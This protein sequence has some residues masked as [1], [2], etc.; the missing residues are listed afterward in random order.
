MSS[1]RTKALLALHERGTISRSDLVT[2]LGIT[3]STAAAIA[4]DLCQSGY[5]EESGGLSGHVGRP[6]RTLRALPTSL[7]IMS[8]ELR[9]DSCHV[10]AYGLGGTH[11]AR[12]SV[13]REM[14]DISPETAASV[15]AGCVASVAGALPQGSRWVATSIAVPGIVEE[16]SGFVA[17]APHLGW[18]DLSWGAHV[19]TAL[20]AKCPITFGNDA[21]LGALGEH[22]R[23]AGR[24]VEAML[25]VAGGI[26]IGGGYV[27][28]G[29]LRT[30]GA[31]FAGEIGH[32][33][34]DP[35]GAPCLCGARG[36]WETLIG[37]DVITSGWSGTFDQL[38]DAAYAGDARAVAIVQQ[39]GRWVGVGLRGLIA[40]T[41]PS[42]VV[43][44]GHLAQLLPLMV[45]QVRRECATLPQVRAGR[46][47]VV[48]GA[49]GGD[50][51]L[52]GGAEVAMVS[53]IRG[54]LTEP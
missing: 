20:G 11:V 19:R 49:L 38:I 3:R 26:G 52:I 47:E 40:I 43:L 8:V 18:R 33:C 2:L 29:R 27:D 17:Y 41:D 4:A 10:L 31:G 45:G 50:A 6:S 53:A 25:Y 36:C 42:R 28:R 54:T 14:A 12:E 22:L 21:N 5:A 30:G 1:S 13:T 24:G 48:P 7:V 46:V 9:V 34:V 15:V 16:R 35:D 23:G 37:R 39:A 44:G 32:M 51:A